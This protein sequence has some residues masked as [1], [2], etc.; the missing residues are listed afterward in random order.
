[1]LDRIAQGHAVDGMEAL[2]P[3]LVDGMELLVDVLPRRHPRPGLRPRAGPRPGDRPGQDL[4]RSSCTPRGPRPPA[5]GRRRSTWVRP[6]TSRSPTSGPPPWPAVWPGGRCRRSAPVRARTRTPVIRTEDGEVVDFRTV[7][8]S[9]RRGDP[10]H[11]RPRPG[12]LPRR[13]RGGASPR[14]GVGSADD[15]RGRAHRRGQGHDRPDGR[16]AHR[17]RAPGAGRGPAGSATRRRDRDRGAGRAAARLRGR[18]ASSWPCSP[19][20][21]CPGSAPPTRRP[22]RCRSGARTRSTRSS[23]APA[24]PWCTTST[25]SAATW[26]WCSAAW[27]ARSASTW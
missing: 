18:P 19:P 26:R 12:H 8:S 13:G 7:A 10:D 23:S 25:A 3:V 1:M 21:T 14:S 5:V 22:A 27:P 2:S 4:A 16:G 11:R 17:A 15:W 20:A 6:P 24:T 9:P